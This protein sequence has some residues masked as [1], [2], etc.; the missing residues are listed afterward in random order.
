MNLQ[1]YITE[2]QDLLKD[3]NALYYPLPQLKRYI[4][5]ARYQVALQTQCI[6]VLIAGNATFGGS[7]SPGYMIPGAITPGSAI[8]NTFQTI[9][10]VERYAYDYANPYV[11]AMNTGVKGV[12][13]VI[14]IAVSWG[15]VRPSLSW[16]PWDDLQAYARSYNIGV[17]SYPFIWSTSGCGERGQVWLFPIPSVGPTSIPNGQGEMEWDCSC[18]PLD[19]Y[20]NEDYEAIPDPFQHYIKFYAAYLALMGSQRYG[21]AQIHLE[22]LNQHLG[23]GQAAGD[24]G[25]V[26]SYYW[27]D[28]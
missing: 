24:M 19:L 27:S 2:T 26:S 3:S 11:R 20:S 17:Y 6:R 15:G 21:A 10:G 18:V 13:D 4:N 14:D 9:Q 23:I 8:I 7:S 12:I 25:K 1:D 28:I 5:Q 22:Y 16:M